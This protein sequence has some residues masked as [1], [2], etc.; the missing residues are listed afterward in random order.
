MKLKNKAGQTVEVP[1]DQWIYAVQVRI[2]KNFH[3]LPSD[4]LLDLDV[5]DYIHDL[6][7]QGKDPLAS[8]FYI[9]KAVHGDKS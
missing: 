3:D 1:Y 8:A 6:Y 5:Q 9:V 4:P 7:K 2:E